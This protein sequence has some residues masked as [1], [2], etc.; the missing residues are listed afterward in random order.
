MEDR[1]GIMSMDRREDVS[2]DADMG[3]PKRS[4]GSPVHLVRY[5]SGVIWQSGRKQKPIKVRGYLLWMMW[6]EWWKVKMCGNG[7]ND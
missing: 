5:L 3:N 7:H 6:H 2:M 4:Q 1:I